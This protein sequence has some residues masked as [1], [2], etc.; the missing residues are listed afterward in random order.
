[1][2]QQQQLEKRRQ[3]L[4]LP[5]PSDLAAAIGRD[6]REPK[7]LQLAFDS[8]VKQQH[9]VI[10][11][12]TATI[13]G[14]GQVGVFWHWGCLSA[15][16]R[17]GE[18]EDGQ[19]KKQKPMP[20]AACCR[21]RR[22]ADAAVWTLPLSLLLLFNTASIRGE[23][24]SFA[25]N[26]R[27]RNEWEP[28]ERKSKG[29]K[30]LIDGIRFF[31]FRSTLDTFFLFS[32]P[33][34]PSQLSNPHPLFHQGAFLGGVMGALTKASGDPSATLAGGAAAGGSGAEMAKQMAAL[35]AGGPL[36][37]ARNFAVMTGVNAGLA[38]AC[39][40]ARG[41]VEDVY[42]T[43]AAAFGSGAAFSLVSG[44]GGAGATGAAAGAAVTV[45]SHDFGTGVPAD[46][47]KEVE[48]RST[49][50]GPR[51]QGPGKA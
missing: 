38:T 27:Q 42:S 17:E 19:G 4:T 24:S 2:A 35:Q 1:M 13:A 9:P 26:T 23:R 3:P 20:T 39:R 30:R 21:R 22:T 41:G 32:S 43:M 15:S 16:A 33:P 46:Y 31:S 11:V 40:K 36:V 45:I 5:Q 25:W 37:Q 28:S 10:E 12:L 6:W 14:S 44:M 47:P 29:A 18:R 34:P 50:G 8:W 51:G 7:K 49:V 48:W